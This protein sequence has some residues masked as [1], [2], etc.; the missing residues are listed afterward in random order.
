MAVG[1]LCLLAGLSSAAQQP[2]KYELAKLAA[3][4]VPPLQTPAEA[5][6]KMQVNGEVDGTRMFSPFYEHM[7]R[8]KKEIYTLTGNQNKVAGKEANA[9]EKAMSDGFGNMST[10]EQAKY[11]K[12]NPALQ[13]ATGVNASMMEFAAKMEDPAFKKKFDAMSDM[14]KAKLVQQYQQPQVQ[15][16]RRNH[17]QQGLNTVMEAAKKV[18]HFNEQ[19]RAAAL[20]ADREAKEKELD[21]KEEA[22]LKPVLAEKSK[23]SAMIGKASPQWV[24]DRYKEMDL[25]AWAIRNEY[26][27]KRL[28]LYRENV[29]ALVNS[30]QLAVKPFDD[31]LAK[32]NYGAALQASNEAK[33]LGQLAGYQEGLLRLISDIQDIAQDITLKAAHFYKEM[34]L[35]RNSY[36]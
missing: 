33:E 2:V 4:V 7:A 25:K 32:I 20:I 14:E 34:Q 22:L 18:S 11:L 28:K 31:Y 29:L 21:K 10:S 3:T 6:A 12:N 8:I 27:E 23:M 36:K 35:V 30:Y 24:S 16:S 9:A 5:F 26:F 13:Q 1:I 17:S 19:Y 15:M